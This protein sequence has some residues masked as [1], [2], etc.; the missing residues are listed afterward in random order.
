MIGFIDPPGR[1]APKQQWLDF[2]AQMK[3]LPQQDDPQVKGAIREAEH[4]LK[5]KRNQPPAV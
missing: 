4:V 3:A 1:F 2:L 5:Q